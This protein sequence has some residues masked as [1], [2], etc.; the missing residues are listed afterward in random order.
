[1]EE[2]H[3]G[4]SLGF[5]FYLI[6]LDLVLETPGSWKSQAENDLRKDFSFYKRT[7]KVAA[8]QD[9]N[10]LDNNHHTSAKYHE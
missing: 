2:T 4:K 1:M 6:I 3:D 9:K 8:E 7:S 10:L 5:S